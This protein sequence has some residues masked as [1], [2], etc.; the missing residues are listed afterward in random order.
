VVV[1]LP[2]DFNAELDAHSGDGR[3]RVDQADLQIQRRDDRSTVRGR[4]GQGGRDLRV[5]T[6]DGSITIRQ[7]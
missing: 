5:R 3:V 7:F 6:G 2:A 4:L 1:E